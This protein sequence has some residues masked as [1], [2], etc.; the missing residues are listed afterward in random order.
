MSASKP[1][2]PWFVAQME[3]YDTELYRL[4]ADS[5]TTAM[6]PGAL[7]YKTKCLIVLALDALKG[8]AQGVKTVAEQARAAG[9]TQA[10]IVEALR[11]A[12]FV[13]GMDIVKIGLNAFEEGR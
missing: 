8:A 3:Q 1:R 9:A 4:S 10:E 13:S 5:V 11:L 12:Y 7:D 6:A 2:L